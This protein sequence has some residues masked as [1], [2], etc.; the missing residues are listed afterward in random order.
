MAQVVRL[1]LDQLRESGL[2]GC[3]RAAAFAGLVVNAARDANFRSIELA[4]FTHLEIIPVEKFTG[5]LLHTCKSEFERW[6]LRNCVRELFERHSLFM[7]AVHRN[8]LLVEQ[9]KSGVTQKAAVEAQRQFANRTSIADKSK[10]LSKEFDVQSQRPEYLSAINLARV[11]ITHRGSIVG[12]EDLNSG[13]HLILR[14][15]AFEEVIVLPDGKE[16]NLW[17]SEGHVFDGE[18][19]IALKFLEKELRF[20]VGQTFDLGPR[21]VQEL[22]IYFTNEVKSLVVSL[23]DFMR[24]RGAELES[25][26][27]G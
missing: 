16:L 18:S 23:A 12:E 26:R 8:I 3:R 13:K 27:Q 19:P 9:V 7:D 24:K 20:E 15:F 5:D 1:N 10:W 4:P 6:G 25:P 17:A 22:V 2:T 21:E 11:C 14:W